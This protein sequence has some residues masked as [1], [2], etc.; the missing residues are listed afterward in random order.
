MVPTFRKEREGLGTRQELAVRTLRKECEGWR[1]SVVVV[2]GRP[3]RHPPFFLQQTGVIPNGG[4][5]QPTEGSRA[6][7]NGTL[8]RCADLFSCE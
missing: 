7:H 2:D 1:T 5:F 8:L 3:P 6:A 4:A